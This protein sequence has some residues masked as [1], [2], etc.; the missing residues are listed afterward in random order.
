MDCQIFDFSCQFIV[1]LILKGLLIGSIYALMALGL[2]LIFSILG[3]V[4]FAH[5]VMYMIGGYIQALKIADYVYVLELG[6]NKFDGSADEFTDL[7]KA[8]WT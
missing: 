6:R 2:T 8:L 5:S 7:E 4:S 3:I 1:R